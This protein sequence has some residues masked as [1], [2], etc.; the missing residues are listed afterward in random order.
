LLHLLGLRYRLLW[1]QAR[2]R[3]GK[4]VLFAVGYLLV[5]LAVTLLGV[6]GL[7]AAAVAVKG[8]Q[9]EETARSILGALFLYA[10]VTSALLGFRIDRAF[11]EAAL[12]RY[13]LTALQRA[14]AQHGA[15]LLDPLWLF[16]LSL[17]LG[18]AVG[19]SLFGA[20]HWWLSALAAPLLVV[21]NYAAARL[22]VGLVERGLCRRAGQLGLLVAGVLLAA[23]LLSRS[24]LRIPVFSQL[25]VVHQVTPSACAAAVMTGSIA[26]RCL[27][28]LTVLLAWGAVLGLALLALERRP[29]AYRAVAGVRARWEDGYDRIAGLFG[30]TLGPLVGKQL[31]Q[32]LRS[33]HLYLNFPLVIPG[34]VWFA[35]QA[36]QDAPCDRP[37]A[38][39]LA[40]LGAFS[41]LGVCIST[42]GLSLNVFGF[43]GAGFRRYFL[44]PVRPQTVL[45]AAALVAMMPGAALLVVAL[46]LWLVLAPGPADLRTLLMLV[47]SGVG[48]LFLHPSLGLW[49]SLL[50]PRPAPLKP[51]F[52]SLSLVAN[53]VM[54]VELCWLM[55]VPFAA[56]H[57]GSVLLRHGWVVPLFAAASAGLFGVTL[58]A[59]GALL[60]RRRERLLSVIDAGAWRRAE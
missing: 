40:A 42:G 22:V 21:A 46:L 5:M 52:G 51:E 53:A 48:G 35:Y 17:D 27:V 41:A 58:A 20:G 26:A 4:V 34:L 36:I 29:P 44:L 25:A 60:V 19:L 50:G 10:M 23:L 16:V 2:T 1:A 6:G 12:R 24:G 11:S 38:L 57:W 49:S 18:L 9:A 59:G 15:A 32:Y 45:L 3:S 37:T 39:F 56:V 31:R 47:S 7:G 13:P 14:V 28:W 30:S 55:G 54:A 43:D 33:A 8:G